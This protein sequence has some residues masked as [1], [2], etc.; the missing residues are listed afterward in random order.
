MPVDGD[1]AGISNKGQDEKPRQGQ[2]LGITKLGESDHH[3]IVPL[4]RLVF[5][6]AEQSVPPG[7]IKAIVAVRLPDDHRMMHTVHIG[8]D[9]EKSKD[10]VNSLW[11]I[12]S[13][14]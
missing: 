6:G 14:K 8:R 9:N 13:I 11:K 2:F 1:A 10:P 3:A 7:E 12:G 5:I 4:F